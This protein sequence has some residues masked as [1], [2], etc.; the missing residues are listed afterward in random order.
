MEGLDKIGFNLPLLAAQVINFL[1]LLGLLY[2]WAYKPILKMFDER[3]RR[4][5]E[6]MDMSDDIMRQA[7]SSGEE[8]KK[9]LEEAAREGQAVIARAMRAGEEIKRKA[10]EDAKPLADAIVA[11]AREDIE[12][13]REEIVAELR[14]EFTNLT[15]T[16]AEKVITEELDPEKHKKL[17]ETVLD[18][19]TILGNTQENS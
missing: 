5:R 3:S 18:E 11:R 2:V 19:S 7:E 4:I 16:A 1:I 10:E 12:H 6:S 14:R 9:K 8:A 15:I 13:E 17:I